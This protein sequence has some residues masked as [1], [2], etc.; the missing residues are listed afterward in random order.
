MLLDAA[1]IDVSTGSACSAGIPEPSH[2]LLALGVDELTARGSL[3]FSLG[4]TSS[5]DD[6][7]ALLTALPSAVERAARAGSAARK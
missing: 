7:D 2:V 4:R 1:G 5:A 6:V 3:R